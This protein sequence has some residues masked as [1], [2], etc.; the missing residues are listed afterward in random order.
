MADLAA[1]QWAAN[2]KPL[3]TTVAKLNQRV[4]QMLTSDSALEDLC[5]VAQS[6]VPRWDSKRIHELYHDSFPGVEKLLE[7]E[8]KTL[9]GW[10]ACVGPGETLWL[11]RCM[12]RLCDSY[13]NRGRWRIHLA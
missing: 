6:E 13:G 10:F 9:S 3:E 4:A 7:T 1:V 2:L 12:G 5:R 11:V 8:F